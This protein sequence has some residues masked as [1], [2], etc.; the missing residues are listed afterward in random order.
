MR[1]LTAAGDRLGS[2]PGATENQKRNRDATTQPTEVDM[3][4]TEV[5]SENT[6]QDSNLGIV[7]MKL[8]VVTLPV[9]DVDRAKS[10]YQ[11]LGWRLD[12]DFTFGDDVRAV[13]LTPPHSN[14]SISF[15]KG[16]TTAEPGRFSAWS[17]SCPTSRRRVMTSSAAAS[18]SASRS[19]ATE[20]SLSRA[21]TPNA[22]P[23]SAM[24][25]SV[26]RTATRGSFRKS[27]HGFRVGCG[28]TDDGHRVPRRP[29]P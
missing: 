20:G 17:W 19:T 26:I 10:F 22:V 3:S 29:T 15:G 5:T 13:Q 8:E 28:R 16:L 2:P 7:D 18:R 25:R 14:T 9:S 24:P 27:R 23:T 11:G 12:A 1:R 4:T 6:A 21:W